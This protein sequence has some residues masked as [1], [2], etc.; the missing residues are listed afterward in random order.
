MLTM[1]QTR[2]VFFLNSEKRINIG[3]DCLFDDDLQYDEKIR[4]EQTCGY[5]KLDQQRL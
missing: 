5:M 4:I 3:R 1:N 2:W